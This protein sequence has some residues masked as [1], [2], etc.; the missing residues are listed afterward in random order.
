[1]TM[2]LAI[3]DVLINGLQGVPSLI[4]FIFFSTIDEA[5]KSFITKVQS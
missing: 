3:S 1:M 2:P 4:I 5:I